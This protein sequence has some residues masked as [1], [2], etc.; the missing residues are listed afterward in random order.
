M[1]LTHR[2]IAISTLFNVFPLKHKAKSSTNKEQSIPSKTALT[3]VWT[4]G[5]VILWT[6]GCQQKNGTAMSVKVEKFWKLSHCLNLSRVGVSVSV[7]CVCVCVSVCV[8]VCMCVCVCVCERERERE[9]EDTKETETGIRS[10]QRWRRLLLAL[11]W[12]NEWK[13]T[14]TTRQA[15]T[16]HHY[17]QQHDIQKTSASSIR[18]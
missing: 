1:L 5:S 10:F 15:N 11:A 2:C 13:A 4:V 7:H 8:C 12:L 9:R 14:S 3:I 18:S 17:N 6:V 16:N